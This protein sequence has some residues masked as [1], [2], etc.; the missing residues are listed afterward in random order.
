MPPLPGEEILVTVFVDIHYYFTAPTPKP[1]HHRFEKGSYLYIY[2][3]V[4]RNTAR[5][6]VANNAGTEY[7]DS[8]QG[9]LDNVHIQHSVEFPTLCTV[10]L[11]GLTGIPTQGASEFDWRLPGSDEKDDWIRLHTL[12]VYFW[13]LDDATQFLDAA[14]QILS[15]RQLETDR[16][17]P[18]EHPDQPLSSVVQQLENVA[19]SD[20]AYQNG[21]TP[22][23]RTNPPPTAPQPAQA[24]PVNLSFPP[25]P[26]SG[27]STYEQQQPTEYQAPPEQPKELEGIAPIPYNPA[28][29]AAPEP[30]KHREKTPPPEDGTEGTGLA[31]AAVADMGVPYTP[32]HQA[33]NVGMSSF[34]PQPASTPGMPYNTA[35]V[36]TGYA[37]PPPSAG[38][39]R[40]NTFS[41]GGGVGTPLQSPGL[42]SYQQAF[43]TG[44]QVP[45]GGM[46]FSP[47]PQDPN[48]H[49]YGQQAQHQQ[50]Q[51]GYSNYGYNQPQPGLQRSTT[52][53][54]IHS[55]VYRPT[56]EE[57]HSHAH[58]TSKKAMK[59]P[60]QRPHG[61]EDKA[62]RVEGGVN[63]FL[64]KLEKKLG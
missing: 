62:S 1:L 29:P 23:S 45:S 4:S 30:I 3:D 32:P 24:A 48:A 36:N 35:A 17:I 14:S 28:A 47:S 13:T 20:P 18:V 54:D 64:K 61:I 50:V 9:L 7:Q 52:E 41:V 38:L 42:P 21:Q 55:Q 11:D 60:G 25:P 22:D 51:S 26:P 43:L 37:S 2:Q 57:V 10:T 63:R 56:M 34:A 49:L 12:D 39:P 58:H 46:S 19:V 44:Q 5:I 40:A 16:D 15:E 6:E 33:N 8:F 31:A 27:P 59:A 53:Y